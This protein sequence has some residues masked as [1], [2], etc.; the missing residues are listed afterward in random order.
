MRISPVLWVCNRNIERDWFASVVSRLGSLRG[1]TWTSIFWLMMVL[2]KFSETR[3]KGHRTRVQ[4][5]ELLSGV[6]RS[7]GLRR[8]QL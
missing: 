2:A 6:D 4:I 3:R 8:G 5:F 1:C 7:Y